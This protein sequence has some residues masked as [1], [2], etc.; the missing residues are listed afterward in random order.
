MERNGFDNSEAG[1]N[2]SGGGL[3]S[4]CIIVGN[5]ADLRGLSTTRLMRRAQSRAEG[6]P[7]SCP[8]F[9]INTYR[10][11]WETTSV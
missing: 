2:E 7:V 4:N 9:Y 1:E 5:A 8:D 10:Q 11:L 3:L 6:P